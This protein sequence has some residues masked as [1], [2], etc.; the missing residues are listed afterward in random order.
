[1]PCQQKEKG[2]ICNKKHRES[3]LSGM[4]GRIK[5]HQRQSDHVEY[6]GLRV[7]PGWSNGRIGIVIEEKE[8]GPH[9]IRGG[10]TR[11]VDR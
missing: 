1:M 7:Y 2:V 4:T 9:G 6:E 10:K 5:E 8:E 11:A 3:S